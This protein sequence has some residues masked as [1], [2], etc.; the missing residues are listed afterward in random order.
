MQRLQRAKK[1]G[2]NFLINPNQEKDV[3]TQIMDLTNG[4]GANFL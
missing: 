1:F 2:A 4:L 3:I